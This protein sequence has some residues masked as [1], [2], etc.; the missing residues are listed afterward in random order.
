MHTGAVAGRDVVLHPDFAGAVLGKC[1]HCLWVFDQFKLYLLI[2]T[3]FLS[4]LLL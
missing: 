4:L 2:L 1:V 3:W